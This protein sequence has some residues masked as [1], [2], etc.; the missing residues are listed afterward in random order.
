MPHVN[1]TFEPF[2]ALHQ[3]NPYPAYRELRDHAPLHRSPESGTWTLSRYDDVAWAFKRPDLF[4]SKIDFRE[5]MKRQGSGGVLGSLKLALR[6]LPR[7]RVSPWK[8]QKSRMLIQ[9]DG[10]VHAAMRQIVN[11]GFTPRRIAA[12]EPRIRAIVEERMVDLRGRDR[13]DLVASLA[14]PLPV[15]VIAEMIGIEP[16]RHADFKRWSDTIIA[17]GTGSGQAQML[18]SGMLDAMAEMRAYLQPLVR[19][20]RRRP[21]DDL[22]SALVETQ[23]GEVALSD[24]EILMFFLLLLVAGNETTTNLIGNAV[25]ALFSHPDQLERAAGDPAS[26]PRLI[27]EA[28]RYDAPVQWLSRRATRDV[29]L[30]GQIIPANAEVALLIGSA[31]RDER[32]FPDPDRFDLGRDTRGHLGFGFGEHFCL[33]ASLARLEARAALEALVPELPRLAPIAS[34]REFLDSYQ[35]RGRARLELAAA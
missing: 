18:A 27:E 1:A 19:E 22:I 12:W 2:S 20:R 3:Q 15:V 5:R 28:L 17:S 26:I 34:D 8:A 31:N 33:G 14:I 25:E 10:E 6:F 29:E 35:I 11:R 30:R 9:S 13:F 23:D 7:M 4:S 32:R 21:T 16:E 24:F